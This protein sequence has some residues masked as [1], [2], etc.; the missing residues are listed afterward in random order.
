MRSSFV[1]VEG[2]IMSLI[3][4]CNTSATLTKRHHTDS[5]TTHLFS[6]RGY[7]MIMFGLQSVSLVWLGH[8]TG[9]K[10]CL[11]P[12]GLDY[13]P[14]Y[15][16]MYGRF[17]PGDRV[18]NYSINLLSINEIQQPT[19]TPAYVGQASGNFSGCISSLI[20]LSVPERYPF[21]RFSFEVCG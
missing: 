18:T 19:R 9:I 2:G 12:N 6:I 4:A 3:T 7:V 15:I 16:Q 14:K 5:K 17:F 1:I 11:F 8:I 20:N 13:Y 21:L 10:S